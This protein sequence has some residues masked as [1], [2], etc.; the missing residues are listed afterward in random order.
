MYAYTGSYEVRYEKF[1]ISHTYNVN[2][3][4]INIRVYKI[5]SYSYI[6]NIYIHSH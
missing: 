3:I 4:Y 1:L 5:F 6:T 2:M